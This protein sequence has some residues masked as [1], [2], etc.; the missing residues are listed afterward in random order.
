MADTNDY[1]GSHRF[2][3]QIDGGESMDGF[4]SV[5]SIIS[6]TEPISFKHGL[7][8]HVRK[9]PGRVT[10]EDITLERVYTGGDDMA[11]WRKDLIAGVATRKN[12][13]IKFQTAAGEDVKIFQLYGSFPVRWELPGLNAQGS[14]SALEKITLCVETVEDIT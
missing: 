4:V 7:D 11:A 8:P 2:S 12:V 13:T 9:A 3:V 6:N 1:L 14:D 5:S 10:W